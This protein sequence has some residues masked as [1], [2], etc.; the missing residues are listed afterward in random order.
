MAGFEE[1]LHIAATNP[2]APVEHEKRA[3]AAKVA[4]ATPVPPVAAREK[5]PASAT[6]VPKTGGETSA[7]IRTLFRKEP[8]SSGLF[9]R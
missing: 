4:D 2:F 7:K 1:A 3:A 6:E 5:Q 9:S 8:D